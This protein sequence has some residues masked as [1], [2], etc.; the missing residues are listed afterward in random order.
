MA[1]EILRKLVRRA[2]RGVGFDLIRYDSVN[3]PVA[4][5]IKLISHHGINLIFDVGANVGQYGEHVRESGYRG[6]IVSFEPVVSSYQALVQVA[7]AD[8]LW[9]TSNVALGDFDGQSEINIAGNTFSSSLLDMLPAHEKSAPESA[10]I[11][12]ETIMVRKIDSIIDNYRREHDRIYLKIDTQGFEKNV[13]E[14]AGKS[15]TNIV[16][17]QM[18][19]SLVPLYKDETLLADMI[20]FM[21][22]KGFTLMS[23]EPGFSD[24]G[25][26]QLLQVD[27]LFFQ[28]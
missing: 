10:Y 16:G 23:I 3:H 8:P 12:K 19:V 27:C 5:R 17:V 4:R 11:R 25:T 18:E 6:R 2:F 9:E 26:G 15:L 20:N 1:K 13:I 22:T 14:G 21:N 28:G 7:S 24:A